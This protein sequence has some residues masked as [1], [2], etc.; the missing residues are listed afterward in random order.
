MKVPGPYEATVLADSIA[1]GTRLTTLA[2]T[3]PRIVLAEFNTHRAFCLAGDSEL[4]FDLPR[5]QRNGRRRV[6]KMRLDTFVD[7]WINGADRKGANPKRDVDLSWIEPETFYGAPTIAARFG[8]ASA[9][10]INRMCRDGSFGPRAEKRGRTW[11]VRGEEIAAW[12]ESRPAHT[13][14]DIRRRLRSMRIRQINELTGDIQWSHVRDV[15]VSGVRD[16]YEL[17]A[18]DDFSV[19]GSRDHRVLTADGWRRLGEI[20]VGDFVVVRKFG[21]RDEDKLDP[22][23][24]KKIDGRWRSVW[25]REQRE[26]LR[27]VDPKCRR[28]GQEDGDHIHHLVPVHL[29]P[30]RAFDES[31]ITLLCWVCHAEEHRTQGW[32][33]GTYLYGS[34]AEVTAIDFRGVEPTYDLEIE[35]EFPNFLANGVVVHNSRNSASSRAIPVK[36][37]IEQIRAE[38]YTPLSFGKNKRGMQADEELT[39]QEARAY[40]VALWAKAA[41]DACDNAEALA[42]VYLHKQ[43]ANRACETYAWHTVI[44]SATEWDNYFAQRISPNAQPEI[45][46]ASEAMRS[47]MDGSVPV[48]LGCGDWHLPAVDVDTVL[49]QIASMPKD[50]SPGCSFDDLM[51]RLSVARCAAISYGRIPDEDIESDLKRYDRMRSMFHMSPFEHAAQVYQDGL[52]IRYSRIPA[53]RFTDRYV[54]CDGRVFDPPFSPLHIPDGGIW[55]IDGY[56]CG[57]FRAPW[58]QH[59]KMIAGEH[60]YEGE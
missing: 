8:M 39:D 53:C 43:W 38:P 29:D 52:Q 14:F 41:F 24:L 28:C 44:V 45:A 25:Q 42:N 34:L 1:F 50:W 9:G 16:V 19:A 57:N 31:N 30:S 49:T 33:G 60:C 12:R 11:Y 26:C 10:N 17:R 35:G 20:K 3:F 5:G 13:R 27:D 6:Y 22:L 47:A 56:F 54:S 21:K 18:G 51:V 23:R 4:E 2:V 55:K 58:L 7:R 32:Q 15:Q 37:R 36:K 48:Q 46:K 59:R 40:A